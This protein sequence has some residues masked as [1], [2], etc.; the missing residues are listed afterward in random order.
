M[1]CCDSFHSQACSL[2]RPKRQLHLQSSLPTAQRCMPMMSSSTRS[3]WD[4]ARCRHCCCATEQM[5]KALTCSTISMVTKP[6]EGMA[7][8]PM[9]ARVAVH[10]MTSSCGSPMD[11]PCACMHP[12][13]DARGSCNIA[14]P[15]LGML[16]PV[17]TNKCLTTT[18]ALATDQHC[19]LPGQICGL[20]YILT[21][22]TTGWAADC[23]PDK[24]HA[25]QAVSIMVI[26]YSHMPQQ[27]EPFSNWHAE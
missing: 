20:V 17:S 23:L 5:P 11:T 27:R 2:R 12:V 16:L 13:H 14:C 21:R 22:Y 24:W 26:R 15:T 18:Q 6:A 19:E 25:V 4:A 7:A 3:L 10:A 8:A 1:L 9:A